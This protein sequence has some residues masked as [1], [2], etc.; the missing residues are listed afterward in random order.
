MFLHGPALGETLR[1]ASWNVTNYAGGRV[2]EFQT[3][4]YGQF[5][6]RSMAPDILVG[7]E[8]AN[9]AAVTAFLNMLNS[10]PGSPADWAAADFVD[11]PD[12]DSAF[13]YRTG[14]VSL[15]T[16][17]SPNGVTVVAVG[18]LAPNHPRNVMRYDV[19]L[20]GGTPSEAR[21]AIY[22][23]HMKSGTAG[24]DESR[25]LL[26][27]QRIRNDAE[28]LPPGWHFI[29]GGDF[30]IQASTQSAYQEMVGSQVNNA[31]RFFD[32]IATPGSWNNNGAF[33]FV[34]TQDPIG[35]SGMDD[36]HDQLLLSASLVDGEGIDYVGVPSSPYSTVTWND[37]NHSYR[38]WGND[39]SSFN[40]SLT[41]TGNQMVGPVIAQA[42]VTTAQSG[43]HL[44]VFLDLD[45]P[46][47]Y[48]V[49]AVSSRFSGVTVVLTAAAGSVALRRGLRI[50]GRA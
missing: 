48:D 1:V 42:L 40:L 15:A 4:I 34:H 10:A 23:T 25:R 22:S 29:V 43:G 8:F 45:V 39:G 26:E 24:S 3:S 30:N 21:L 28:G 27:A 20:A 6:G 9:A 47:V 7:Q 41:I 5:E 35:A 46:V 19:V 31:G 11:G 44:P 18:G 13:F 33:R 17:L 2:A 37:P 38:S 32:P 49:P 50:H 16:D 36:R 12:T 14:A